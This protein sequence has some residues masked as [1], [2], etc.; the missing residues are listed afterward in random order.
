MIQNNQQQQMF[1]PI[2]QAAQQSSIGLMNSIEDCK[3]IDFG[4]LNSY[5]S[6]KENKTNKSGAIT[7]N[8]LQTSQQNIAGFTP[9][10]KNEQATLSGNARLS[11]NNYQILTPQNFASAAIKSSVDQLSSVRAVRFD[12]DNQDEK[13]QSTLNSSASPIQV[14]ASQNFRISQNEVKPLYYENGSP[15]KNSMSDISIKIL[16]EILN[17]PMSAKQTSK[18]NR[19]S[20]QL[21][22][23]TYGLS[24]K[25][26]PQKSKSPLNSSRGGHINNQLNSS[27][28]TH[29]LVQVKQQRNGGNTGRDDSQK[30]VRNSQE[31]YQNALSSPQVE[32]QQIIDKIKEK[33]NLIEGKK[34]ELEFIMAKISNQ[35]NACKI[36]SIIEN[37]LVAKCG[38]NKKKIDQISMSQVQEKKEIAKMEE[39]CAKHKHRITNL[40]SKLEIIKQQEQRY[41]ILKERK[42]KEVKEEFQKKNSQMTHMFNEVS[43]QYQEFVENLEQ[44]K[45]NHNI[46]LETKAFLKEDLNGKL[47]QRA[48]LVAQ[49]EDLDQIFEQFINQY[50][51]EYEYINEAYKIDVTID[52]IKRALENQ[53]NEQSKFSHQIGTIFSKL[54]EKES[55]FNHYNSKLE[56]LG[57]LIKKEKCCSTQT[58]EQAEQIINKISQNNKLPDLEIMCCNFIMMFQGEFFNQNGPAIQ[59]IVQGIR[60]QQS[61]VTLYRLIDYFKQTYLSNLFKDQDMYLEATNNLFSSLI[62]LE[63]INERYYNEEQEIVQ[64]IQKYNIELESLKKELSSAQSRIEYLQQQILNDSELLKKSEQQKMVLNENL[65]IPVKKS[66]QIVFQQYCDKQKE[67]FEQIANEHGEEQVENLMKDHSDQF[68]YL[69]TLQQQERMQRMKDVKEEKMQLEKSITENINIVESEILPKLKALVQDLVHSKM[70]LD[71]M[72]NDLENYKEAKY[73]VEEDMKLLEKC[74]NQKVNEIEQNLK[75]QF[76]DV[77]GKSEAIEGDL[78]Q[79]IAQVKEQTQQIEKVKQSIESHRQLEQTLRD[80]ISKLQQKKKL[81]DD[82]KSQTTTVQQETCRRELE[83][84][85]LEKQIAKL[86]VRK[87]VLENA[88]DLADQQL[89][90]Q[91]SPIHQGYQHSKNNNNYYHQN[92]KSHSKSYLMPNDGPYNFLNN[93]Q[94]Q[95]PKN[96]YINYSSQGMVAPTR[97]SAQTAFS[98]KGFIDYSTAQQTPSIVS[99]ASIS[100]NQQYTP[101]TNPMKQSDLI[102]TSLQNIQQYSP[103]NSQREIPLNSSKTPSSSASSSQNM[104]NQ[105]I[106]SN[107]YSIN[108]YNPQHSQQSFLQQYQSAS[109]IMNQNFMQQQSQLQQI[110]QNTIKNSLSN[111]NLKQ[112]IQMPLNQQNNHHQAQNSCGIDLSLINKGLQHRINNIANGN[113]QNILLNNQRSSQSKSPFGSPRD[114]VIYYPNTCRTSYTQ[115]T[116][117]FCSNTNVAASYNNKNNQNSPKIKGTWK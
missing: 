10:A 49:K 17:S 41:H 85:E 5:R 25:K 48:E 74:L 6:E 59:Q 2:K 66:A 94:Q 70:Q 82:L 106:S 88:S 7:P 99:N 56:D 23:S 58:L 14:R 90:E 51:E 21:Q 65:K 38:E 50:P 80:E 111:Q 103:L 89:Q 105:S 75:Q 45:E 34:S 15:N 11:N 44:I 42:V 40:Q 12:A 64:L 91:K 37:A 16:N 69:M 8:R 19:V 53:K 24:R 115:Q 114:K 57:E 109:P 81:I 77:I 73:K 87:L 28:N 83:I 55:Y 78:N 98:S 96:I 107:S 43:Q 93:Q 33:K 26:S 92:Q 47:I 46:D 110:Q 97:A 95:Q 27:Y 1:A 102:S 35:I 39:I 60:Y 112:Q 84:A 4:F 9:N 63:E 67:Q 30:Q 71:M 72:Y 13:K 104:T 32:L 86:E 20:Q 68:L 52:E 61:S 3:I 116:A 76:A 29:D 79:E 100:S 54:K 113:N 18:Q 101:N 117:P 108:Q 36:N 31:L 22:S 62:Q